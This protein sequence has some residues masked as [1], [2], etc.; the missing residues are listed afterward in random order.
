MGTVYILMI[1][2]LDSVEA[3][4]FVETAAVFLNWIL[5]PVV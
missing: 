2:G 4:T 5:V 1:L 3:L